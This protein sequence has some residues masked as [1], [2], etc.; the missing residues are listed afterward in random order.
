MK[1]S[2][3][4]EQLQRLYNHPVPESCRISKMS[5]YDKK[6]KEDNK[7]FIHNWLKK[8]FAFL[9]HNKEK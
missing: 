5:F 3:L 2:E 1:E 6:C 9:P 8:V 7:R 4:T